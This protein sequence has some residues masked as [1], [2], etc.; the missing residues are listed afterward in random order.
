MKHTVSFSLQ[1][2]YKSQVARQEFVSLI[3]QQFKIYSSITRYKIYSLYRVTG[4]QPFRLHR[5]FNEINSV[6]ILRFIVSSSWK[7]VSFFD[8][9]FNM[10]LEDCNHGSKPIFTPGRYI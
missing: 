7:I 4:T 6:V 9:P 3:Q 1:E 5:R 8:K 10:S 2:M